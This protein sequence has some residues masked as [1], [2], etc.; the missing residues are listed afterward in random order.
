MANSL[1]G[2]ECRARELVVDVGHVWVEQDAWVS[3]V[4]KLSAKHTRGVRGA[5]AS[6]PHVEALRVVL[7]SVAGD[8][9]VDGD[10]LVAEDVV[11]GRKGSRHCGRPAAVV[12]DQDLLC[13]LLGGGVD[14]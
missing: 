14:N 11:A 12:V 13:P 5:R 3:P 10:E 6:D 4:V 8:S 9:G 1:A 2:P 7:R